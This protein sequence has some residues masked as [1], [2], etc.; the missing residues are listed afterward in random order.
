M[1]IPFGD[2]GDLNTSQN[3]NLLLGKVVRIDVSHDDFPADDLRDYAIPA[4]NTF[5]ANPAAG[6]PEIYA[7][8]LRNP[9]R[10]SFDP[11]SGDLIIA[12]VG[13]QRKEEIN[14]LPLDDNSRN[15]GWPLVEGTLPLRGTQTPDLTLPVSEY[16][17]GAGERQ[18]ESIIGGYVYRGPVEALQDSYIFGDFVNEFFWSVPVR[19]LVDGQVLSSDAYNILTDDFVPD[20]SDYNLVSSFGED[21][22]GNI[23]IASY[24][25]GE[26]F[27]MEAE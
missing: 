12:D 13:G 3:D 14:R 1:L 25:G 15:F 17:H 20:V 7:K 16:D 8:G 4:G 10:A 26:I 2:G 9:F 6:L 22:Q 18:G 11:V 23:Y 21:E 27:R 24:F 5:E 19:D